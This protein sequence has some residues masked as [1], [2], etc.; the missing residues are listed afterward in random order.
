MKD[1]DVE[2]RRAWWTLLYWSYG[3]DGPLREGLRP[4]PE[5]V[6]DS[7]GMRTNCDS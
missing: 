1:S 7:K 3:L 4:A 6:F 2:F 5:F